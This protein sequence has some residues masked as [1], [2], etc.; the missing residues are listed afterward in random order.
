M[1]SKQ[2]ILDAAV[3]NHNLVFGTTINKTLSK[4]DRLRYGDSEMNHA[5]L[6]TGMFMEK[7][8]LITFHAKTIL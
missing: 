4:A 7:V 8:I 2:G 6:F 1:A 5:M 3:H